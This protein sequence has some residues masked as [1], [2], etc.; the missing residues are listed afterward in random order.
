MLNGARS[1]D[2]LDV[3]RPAPCVRW[4][5]GLG[6][7]KDR[8]LL[9]L[10]LDI[11]GLTAPHMPIAKPELADLST[12]APRSQDR[13]P[14][15]RGAALTILSH[16]RMARAGEQL[17]FER[18]AAGREVAVSRN[19]PDFTSP[20]RSL[21]APLEDPYV[22]RTPIRFSARD[23][24]CVRMQASAAAGVVVRVPVTGEL[25]F[26]P[27][28]LSRG[29]P[30]EIAGRVV[31]LLHSF[32]AEPPDTVDPLGMVG[33]SSGIR[34]VRTAIDRIAD[35]AVPVLIR[36]ETGTGKELVAR[37]IHGR[38]ARRHGPFLSVNL[39]AL[40]RELAAPE[41]FGAV[42]GAYTGAARDRDGLFR[43]A[44][45]GTL[46]LDEVGEA[47]PEVQVMLLRVLETGE[48]FPVGADRPVPIDV[49][50]VAATDADLEGG[51]RAGEFKAPLLHRLAGYEIRVPPLR[52]RREDIGPLF[53]HFA[54]EAL[55]AFGE[56]HRLSPE[57]PYAEP[58]LP[59][60]LATQLVCHRWP[61]NLRQL[62]NVTRQLVIQSRGL[63]QLRI[64][65]TLA[66]ELDAAAA[67]LELAAPRQAA[68][69][70]GRRKP[71]EVSEAELLAALAACAWDLKAAADRL[72]IPRPS[73]YHLIERHPGIRTA[74][75]L[76]ADEIAR[77]FRDCGGDLDAMVARLQVSKRALKRRV[78]ELGLNG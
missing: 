8:S 4:I 47:S 58:W 33:S 56:A 10:R 26:T 21:G 46:F 70:P 53:R 77:C 59:A 57:D 71:A 22:S 67:D 2:I 24:G 15:R 37:A 5:G 75:D 74:G 14:S 72:Q 38:S 32:D 63:P 6:G 19:A 49:R 61:G 42:R 11:Q 9:S 31:L 7:A 55:A 27:D 16:P 36:G 34:Q 50:L 41:L 48:L 23:G 13:E 69:R 51:I 17:V 54:H 68:V 73:I 52:D 65:P 20:G 78:R 43:A 44:H 28:D 76:G 3:V 66:A 18:V 64:D 30:I 40:P 25:E 12:L 1:D 39:G 35:L 45:G 60:R 29:I 62:R